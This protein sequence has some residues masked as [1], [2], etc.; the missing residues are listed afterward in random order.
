MK[1]SWPKVTASWGGDVVIRHSLPHLGNPDPHDHTFHIRIGWTHEINKRFG[2]SGFP[3]A[4]IVAMWRKL[5]DLIDGQDLDYVMQ[6]GIVPT[7]ECLACWLLARCPGFIAWVEIKAYDQFL[8][9]VDRA[10]MRSEEVALLLDG[11]SVL[12][13]TT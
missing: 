9:H 6:P 1:G 10:G 4:K 5:V 7:A 8:V 12:D 3:L 2:H 11:D 13:L